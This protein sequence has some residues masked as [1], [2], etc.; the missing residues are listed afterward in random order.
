MLQVLARETRNK[1]RFAAG[2]AGVWVGELRNLDYL[3]E[4]DKRSSGA[5]VSSPPTLSKE[6]PYIAKNPRHYIL[7]L[8]IMLQLYKSKSNKFQEHIQ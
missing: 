6:S 3:L 7:H 8:P 4:I 5:L 1:E 2:E